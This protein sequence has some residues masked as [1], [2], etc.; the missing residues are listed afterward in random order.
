MTQANV[1]HTQGTRFQRGALGED[2]VIV[3]TAVAQMKDITPPDV[4][5][6]ILDATTIDQYNGDDPDLYKKSVG[7]NIEPGNLELDMILDPNSPEQRTLEGDIE[8]D[9]PIDYRILYVDDS[10]RT[11]KGVLQSIKPTNG[12]DD[13]C[14][15]TISI[16]VSG[17]PVYSTPV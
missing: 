12:F 3:W 4:S 16:K 7:G 5:R 1:L 11:M 15:Q 8:A 9:A 13:I 2:D 14:R 10:T 17:K 6:S